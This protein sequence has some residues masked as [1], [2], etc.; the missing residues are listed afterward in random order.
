MKNDLFI[1]K[2]LLLERL[3]ISETSLFS[4]LKTF[5]IDS[6][7]TIFSEKQVRLF[8]SYFEKTNP[9]QKII[10]LEDDFTQQESVYSVNTIVEKFAKLVDKRKQNITK[11]QHQP[12]HRGA[13]KECRPHQEEARIDILK[14]LSVSDRCK[15]ISACG[16]GKTLTGQRVMESMIEDKNTSCCLVLL[17]TLDLIVQFFVSM[18]ANSKVKSHELPLVICSDFEIN[19]STEESTYS[20]R[21]VHCNITNSEM[22]ILDFLNNET[23]NHKLI[24][25]TYQSVETL[26]NLIKERLGNFEIN[27]AIF[28][29]A[30]K[31]AGEWDKQFSYALYNENIKIEKRLFMTATPKENLV[32]ND[33]LLGMENETLYGK[34][35]HE[36]SMDK[37]IEKGIIRDYKIVIGVINKKMFE[38]ENTDKS[39]LYS[40][41]LQEMMKIKS[42]KKGIIFH[43]T[44]KESQ[45]FVKTI[46]ER[47]ILS[48]YDFSHIDGTM[49]ARKRKEALHQLEKCNNFFLSNSRLLSEGVDVPSI[50][51][52]GL[53]S[54]SKSVVDIAQR[55]GRAQRI[56]SETK[57]A[58]GYVFLPLVIEDEIDLTADTLMSKS[59]LGD[60]LDIILCVREIDCRVKLGISKLFFTNKNS[61]FGQQIE[62]LAPDSLAEINIEGLIAQNIKATS[63]YATDNRWYINFLKVSQFLN[64]KKRM[65]KRSIEDE[66][67]LCEWCNKYKKLRTRGLLSKEKIEQLNSIGFIWNSFDETWEKHFE[68]LVEF[69]K[70][71][72][73]EPKGLNGNKK[74]T[75]KRKIESDLASWLTHQKNAYSKGTLEKERFEKLNP[76]IEEWQP[77]HKALWYSQ[78][79]KF[80]NFIDKYERFP[81]DVPQNTEEKW[82]Y[83]WIVTQRRLFTLKKLSKEY[84]ECLNSVYQ[85]WSYS[86]SERLFK[87]QI[88]KLLLFT[89][90]NHC[91]P[92]RNATSQYEKNLFLW[93]YKQK[94]I[95]ECGML[96]DWQKKLILPYITKAFLSED[97]ILVKMEEIIKYQQDRNG[98][99]AVS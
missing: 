25:S 98:L 66:K 51:A 60:L 79:G 92:K 44:I 38:L 91:L 73:R 94:K 24:L 68:K 2:K 85:D 50:E 47:N 8:V 34:I 40:Y 16:T 43:N 93:L 63:F 89:E 29:E 4:L 30:H 39:L 82:I 32:E 41:A 42:V 19:N 14:E 12:P 74:S 31:T 11:S 61:N 36:L 84:I 88:M 64:E 21:A 3:G 48:E 27:F 99:I 23:L 67:S 95:Y 62:I 9:E 1:S 45:E 26:G 46:K 54:S 59:N 18:K 37:A 96:T 81:E 33:A 52:V 69:I 7:T 75:K 90:E 80:K 17:P 86:Y 15:Y 57:E 49:P 55:I 6:N 53:F 10:F 5:S 58:F 83:R 72:N 87:K 76:Y 22:K 56:N 78:L 20:K 97:T 65:P 35:A 13:P 70:E 28:D 71:N 77:H